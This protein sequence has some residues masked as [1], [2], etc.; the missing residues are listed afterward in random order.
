MKLFKNWFNNDEPD[1][2][3]AII[4][5]GMTDALYRISELEKENERLRH[6][7]M[8]VKASNT[9]LTEQLSEYKSKFN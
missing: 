7:C 6:A 4:R 8:V 9:L 1:E 5:Y 3:S 2:S